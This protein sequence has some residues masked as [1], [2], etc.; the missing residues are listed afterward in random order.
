MFGR[1]K[2]KRIGIF[3]GSFNPP[4]LGHR[5]IVRHLLKNSIVDEVWVMPCNNHKQKDGLIHWTHR[6]A[7]CEYTFASVD[8]AHVKSFDCVLETDG[9]TIDI[10]QI[11]QSMHGYSI[12]FNIIVGQDNADEFHT[13]KEWEKLRDMYKF[14][15][16]PRGE[17]YMSKYDW[18]SNKPHK[19]LSKFN[20]NS[21][22]STRVRENIEIFNSTTGSRLKY[23]A[24]DYL[25]NFLHPSVFNYIQDHEFYRTTNEK[26][27]P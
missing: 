10:M 26:V 12:D 18:Y 1:K 9:S 8:N 16:F 7:M 20:V 25:D 14:I 22:S 21:I 3:G 6:L 19:F 2:Q 17:S 15:V 4:T 5:A 13:W 23:S 27:T 11:L 24:N